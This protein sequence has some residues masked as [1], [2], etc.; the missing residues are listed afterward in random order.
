[1]KTVIFIFGGIDVTPFRSMV[2]YATDSKLPL[3]IIMFDSNKKK[4]MN[5]LKKSL[6]SG[7]TW[8]KI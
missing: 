5:Y 2:K 1:L 3:K 8:I 4:R 6:M 7:Q